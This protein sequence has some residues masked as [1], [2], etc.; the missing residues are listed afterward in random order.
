[1]DHLGRHDRMSSRTDGGRSPPPCPPNTPVVPKLVLTPATPEA[2]DLNIPELDLRPPALAAASFTIPEIVVTP[3]GD[4]LTEIDSRG[5]WLLHERLAPSTTFESMDSVVDSDA[6]A[7]A[8]A[9]GAEKKSKSRVKRGMRKFGELRTIK[10][11]RVE[12]K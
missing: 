11:R 8:E 7:K 5:V 12:H 10:K 1:M 3:S 4:T 2:G 9:E 6:K